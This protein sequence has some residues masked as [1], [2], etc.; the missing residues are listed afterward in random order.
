MIEPIDTKA[1]H[2]A[3]AAGR[4]PFALLKPSKGVPVVVK[5][6]FALGS[7]HVSYAFPFHFSL[8]PFFLL[9]VIAFCLSKYFLFLSRYN[10]NLIRL[11][12]RM[13]S[14]FDLYIVALDVR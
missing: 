12:R 11:N 4:T 13:E 10:F 6:Q 8:F 3:L 5:V 9:I 7:K 2:R 14:Q 1:M